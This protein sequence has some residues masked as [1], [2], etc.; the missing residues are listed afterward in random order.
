MVRERRFAPP[1]SKNGAFFSE[2]GMED[3]ITDSW[4]QEP[5]DLVDD[6]EHYRSYQEN[7]ADTWYTDGGNNEEENA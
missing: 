7:Q 1:S 2:R 4:I 5:E 3:H 6:Y